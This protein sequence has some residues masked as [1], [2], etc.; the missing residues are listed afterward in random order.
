MKAIRRILFA[1]KDPHRLRQPAAD[2]VI[3]LA[4]SLGAAIDFFHAIAEPVVL[5]AQ[6]VSDASLES[7]RA[8]AIDRQHARL[9]RL[10]A[11]AGKLGV[12]ATRAAVWDYPPHESIVRRAQANSADLIVCE[13]HAGRRLLPWLLH[14]T[15]WEL[16]RTS[17]VPVLLIRNG[18]PWRKLRVLAAV[19]PTHLNAKPARLDAAIIAAGKRMARSFGGTL[20]AMH[21]NSPQ[22][23][24]LGLV[25]PVIGAATIAAVYDVQHEAAASAF[26]RFAK[27]HQIPVRRRRLVDEDPAHGIPR[28]ARELAAGLVVMGALSRSGLKRV[29]IGNTAERV[30]HALP[31]DVLVIKPGKFAART[32]KDVRGMRVHLGSSFSVSA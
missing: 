16:L 30:L 31:C 22:V 19:D 18:V 27:R 24:A 20:F 8:V 14:L 6:P 26:Q 15:D 28:V 3:R 2:K 13:F 11:R 12:T 25:D 32:R 4:R 21:A 5:R 17:P 9:D 1:V 10:V 7:L 23:A 29:L